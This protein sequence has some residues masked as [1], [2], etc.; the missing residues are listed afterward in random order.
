[1]ATM[2]PAVLF[3][4]LK[5]N[6]L[7]YNY[8]QS[9]IINSITILIRILKVYQN[10]A[11]ASDIAHLCDPKCAISILIHGLSTVST[12]CKFYS[13]KKNLLRF[14]KSAKMSM[15]YNCFSGAN[16]RICEC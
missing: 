3:A 16:T 9:F 8:N 1:M 12:A 2:V 5:E 15:F 6:S 10:C 7:N 11:F 13:N 14:L 4:E